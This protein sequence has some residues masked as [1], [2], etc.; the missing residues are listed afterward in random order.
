MMMRSEIKSSLPEASGSKSIVLLAPVMISGRSTLPE[1][2]GSKF[3]YK[4]SHYPMKKY[5]FLLPDS[6]AR[7]LQA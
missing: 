3:I 5:D 4:I 7:L 1:A 6:N 2:S